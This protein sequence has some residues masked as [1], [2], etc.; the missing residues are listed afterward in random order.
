MWEKEI[1]IAKKINTIQ[2]EY[3][4][5]ISHFDK[6]I[7]YGINYQPLTGDTKFKEYGNDKSDYYRAFVDRN[8]YS[9]KIRVGYKCYLCDGE[10]EESELENMA[11]N[12]DEYCNKANYEVVSVLPQN[13]KIRIDFKKIN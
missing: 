8:I 2:D 9:G 4:V 5:D 13:L 10:I 1:W 12:D 11:T 7:K 6:P 3:G